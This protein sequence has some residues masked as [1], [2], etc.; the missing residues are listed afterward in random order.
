MHQSDRRAAHPRH[1]ERARRPPSAIQRVGVKDVRYP[2]QLQDR[3]RGAAHRGRR[4]PGRG[5]A[6]GA[7]G[8]A[9]VALRRAGSTR[10]TRRSMPASVARASCA[11]CS[12]RSTPSEGR[13]EARFPFFLRKRAPVSGVQSLL[14]YQGRW[15]ARDPRRRRRRAVAEVVRAGHQ[16]VPVLEGDLRL[17]RAQPALARDDP[18]SSC[19]G[20]SRGASWC[21]SP[22]TR[23]RARSGRCSSAPT[24]SGSPSA[25][26]RTR[27]SSRTWCATSRCALNADARIGRY[28]VDVE[29]FESIHAHSAVARIEWL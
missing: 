3:R 29:N 15:I 24:R 26:T 21:A 22:R 20:R 13:I 17:R 5:P 27:S 2:L 14:D 25:P 9:H 23:P 10:S 4:G 28:S 18:A 19:C 11:R 1:A 12:T 16:P 6:G 8:H 7:E